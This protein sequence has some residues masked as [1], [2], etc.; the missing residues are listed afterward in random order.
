[1]QLEAVVLAAA[2]RAEDA[3]DALG[4]CLFDESWHQGVVGLVAG[5]IKDRLHRPVIAFARAENGS[6]RGS[7]RSVAGVNIRDALDSI[8]ARRPGLVD[9]F[10]GHAMAAGLSLRE[11]NLAD[12][13]VEFAAE[14]ASRADRDALTGIIYSDGALNAAELCI[15]TAQ[16]LR[17]AG[18]WGQG[19]PEPIF[20][21]QFEVM[22]ARIV[23][24]K[25][26]KMRLR[27]PEPGSPPMDAIAFGY[28]GGPAEDA[29]HGQRRGDT[30]C[31]PARNQRVPRR[32]AR[33]AELPAPQARAIRVLGFEAMEVNQIK[34]SIKDLEERT[35]SLR[36]YL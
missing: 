28:V 29:G 3:A 9:K 4:V 23:G 10:G 6:L 14:I 22:E 20:D 26:L 25:H 18:P 7:A 15:D 30:A 13:R 8:A 1:M 36:R 24:D 27:L 34:R 19:F 16:A 33:A 5:R 21:G 31:L 2:M 17:G 35:D 12:F 11:E 32:R